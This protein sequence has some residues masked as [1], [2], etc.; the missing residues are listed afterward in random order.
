GC[1]GGSPTGGR[2]LGV[3]R[4]LTLPARQNALVK[5]LSRR[6]IDGESLGVSAPRKNL[7]WAWRAESR[8]WDLIRI[9]PAWE[10]DFDLSNLGVLRAVFSGSRF[11]LAASLG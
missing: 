11:A 9:M 5:V 10:S 8:P 1:R 2:L 4:S 3:L 7:L 6:T